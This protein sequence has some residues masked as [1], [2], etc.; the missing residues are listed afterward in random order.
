MASTVE[1]SHDAYAT[2]YRDEVHNAVELR[3]NAATKSMAE[4]DF[5]SGLEHLTDFLT[6]ER[7]PNV[8][9]DVTEFGYRPASDFSPWRDAN[10]I[11]RY[12]AAGVK[13]FA[14][15][16]PA[17]SPN[18]VEGGHEPAEEPPGKFPTGYFKSRDRINAWFDAT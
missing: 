4:S 12:N 5:R 16:V 10:I 1:L 17:G 9:I 14:F 8:L 18:T 7:V 6:A 15:L 2:F 13:K 3:W 11:P